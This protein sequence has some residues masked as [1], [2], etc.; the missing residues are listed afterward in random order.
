M[1][2]HI[3]LDDALVDELDARI[4]RGRRSAFLTALLQ[5]ALDDER[6]WDRVESALG[7]LGDEGHEWDDDPAAWVAAQRR[8]DPARLG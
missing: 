7:A 5:R 3:V 6:R 4:G 8:A 1:R 2:L